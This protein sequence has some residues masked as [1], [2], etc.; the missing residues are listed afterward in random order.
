LFIGQIAIPLCYYSSR[1]AALQCKYVFPV[2]H[3]IFLSDLK[4]N[5]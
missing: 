1:N 4:V 2:E 5:V 3:G